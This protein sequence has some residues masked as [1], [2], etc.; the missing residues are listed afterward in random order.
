MRQIGEDKIEI[1]WNRNIQIELSL[2]E[3]AVYLVSVGGHSSYEIQDKIKRKYG[4]K[5][6]AEVYGDSTDLPQELYDTT[7][8][9]LEKHGANSES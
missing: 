5:L 3:L 1:N 8:S 4:A 9:L 6:A 7:S 2:K